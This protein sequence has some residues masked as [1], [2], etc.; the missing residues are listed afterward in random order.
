MIET[1]IKP[2]AP[3]PFEKNRNMRPLCVEEAEVD[4]GEAD[5]HG[6][7]AR[8]QDHGNRTVQEASASLHRSF[9]DMAVFFGGH[10]LLLME[11]NSLTRPV[12]P[13]PAANREWRRP[14]AG[15]PAFLGATGSG[16][17]WPSPLQARRSRHTARHWLL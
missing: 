11:D 2:A 13:A 15:L 3:T 5:H 16:H 10:V 6:G 8:D 14:P 4:H 9:D 17:A 7:G 12:V 1:A